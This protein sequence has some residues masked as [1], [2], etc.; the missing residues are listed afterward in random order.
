[1]NLVK[2]IIKKLFILPFAYKQKAKNFDFYQV[3]SILIR[4]T[5]YA[6]GDSVVNNAYITQLRTIYPNARLGMIVTKNSRTIYALNPEINELVEKKFLS[7]IKQRKRWDIL[8]D[9]PDAFNTSTVILDKILSPKFTIIFD[10]KYKPV[11]NTQEIHN[12]DIQTTELENCHTIDFISHSIFKN[13]FSIPE[14]KCELSLP[15]KQTSQV[16]SLWA[17]DKIRIL[18]APQGSKRIVPANE[19]ANLLKNLDKTLINHLDI[20][21]NVSADCADEYMKILTAAEIQPLSIKLMPSMPLNQYLELIQS[22]DLV[23]AVDSGS[24]HLACALNKPL[25]CFY[26]NFPKNIARWFAKPNNNVPFIANIPA[27]PGTSAN[28]TFGFE[29]TESIIW[30]NQQLHSLIK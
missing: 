18:I 30:L 25:L 8:L 9:M 21:V 27:T 14:G 15:I 1:M 28:D 23:I 3:N 22:S 6:L 5:G 4:P 20:L 19:I 26:A 24:V 17:K 7:F 2:S 29:L 12:F 11:L 10:K 16:A 13:Y